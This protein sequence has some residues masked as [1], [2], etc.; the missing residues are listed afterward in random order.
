MS[1]QYYTRHQTGKRTT[2]KPVATDTPPVLPDYEIEAEQ[3]TTLLSTLVISMLMS[4]EQ[5]LPAH[6]K[7][8]REVKLLEAAVLRF[9]SINGAKVEADLVDVGVL[10]WGAALQAMQDGLMNLKRAEVVA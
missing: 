1:E 3:V 5:Q 2:Y 7:I 9:A 8:A 10:A 6:A 4:I